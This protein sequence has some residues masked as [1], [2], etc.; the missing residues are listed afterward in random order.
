MRTCMRVPARECCIGLLSCR[1]DSRSMSCYHCRTD[2]Q[3]VKTRRLAFDENNEFIKLQYRHT[4]R[5]PTCSEQ[6]ADAI[7]Q[8]SLPGLTG[9]RTHAHQ[10]LTTRE[11]MRRT[12]NALRERR[13]AGRMHAIRSHPPDLRAAPQHATARSAL[14]EATAAATADTLAR[15]A[16]AAS[17]ALAASGAGLRPCRGR[18]RAATTCARNAEDKGGQPRH[19][20]PIRRSQREA[21]HCGR[22]GSERKQ[23]GGDIRRGERWCGD[24][25]GG[26]ESGGDEKRRR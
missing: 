3:H 20:Q 8:L 17:A 1:A 5:Q 15:A 4:Q 19:K 25:S 12:Y 7:R 22:A 18:A 16:A 14:L 26:D 2:E 24:E 13:A 23:R 21:D 10:S 9:H 6:T 11:C